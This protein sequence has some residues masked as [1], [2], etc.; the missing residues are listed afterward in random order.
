[1]SSVPFI[2]DFERAIFVAVRKVF[3][4]IHH[5]GCNFHHQQALVKRVKEL[6]LS[7]TYSKKG[8]NPF[9][10]FIH[11]LMCLSYLPHNK[12]PN[13][14]KTL[15]RTAPPQAEQL[16]QYFES[17]WVKSTLW[18]PK[19]W[20]CFMLVVRTNNDAE[21]LHNLWNKIGKSAK[22]PFY[23]LTDVLLDIE[24]EVPLMADMLCYDKITSRVKKETTMK[25][26]IL[27]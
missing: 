19:H 6:G 23:K 3:P 4:Q 16:V 9:R 13:V 26:G 2:S 20:S 27:F 11:K 1:M 8:E 12:I 5:Q 15:K 25:N 22:L 21:G 24:K 18:T 10:D 14:F 7:S 17:N